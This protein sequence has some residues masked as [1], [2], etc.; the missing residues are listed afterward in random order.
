[1][2][3]SMGDHFGTMDQPLLSVSGTKNGNGDNELIAA[4]AAGNR[5]VIVRYS[6]QNE[7]TTA[8]TLILKDGATAFSRVLAQ[9][10][11]DGLTV[12]Y[13]VGR[14]KRLTAATALN[15]N[16]SGANSCGYSVDYFIER[17]NV[18]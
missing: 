13:P 2:A 17:A 6:I 9:N 5:I 3:R 10:Q 14:E 4:P 8:T 18:S 16:L 15:M 1:M 12:H 11:G 7:S